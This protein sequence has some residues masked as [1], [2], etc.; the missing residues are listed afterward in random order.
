MATAADIIKKFSKRPYGWNTDEIV[1][2]MAR[3]GLANKIIF[4]AN[5]QNVELRQV[6]EHL[7]KSQKRAN[8]RIRKIKQQSEANLK[9]AA[10]LFKDLGFGTAPNDEKELFNATVDNTDSKLKVWLEKL[11]EFK[12][13]SSTGAYPGTQEIE[14]GIEL[15]SSLTE[16]KSSFQF[17]DQ[18]IASDSKLRN[19]EEEYEELENFYETQF[20]M[21]QGLERAL[22]ISFA[23]NRIFL[24]K[25]TEAKQAIDKLEAIYADPRPYREIRNIKPLI[26]KVT[27]IDKT[28]VEQQREFTISRLE[29]RITE[30]TELV[31]NAAATPEISNRALL[32]F[33]NA[34]KRVRTED[35]VAQIK[36]E[37]I[38]SDDWF[39]AAETLV[40]DY[41]RLRHAQAVKAKEEADKAAEREFKTAPEITATGTKPTDYSAA[42]TAT[43]P[44]AESTPIAIPKAKPTQAIDAVEVYRAVSDAT[45]MESV[46][47][48]DLYITALRK[49]LTELVESNHKVR[50]R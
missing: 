22:K 50:I 16:L 6:Y 37:L 39:T 34:I 41:I 31:K 5:Q 9:K 44:V 49:K 26:E 47:D 32:P 18:F 43:R 1:L 33:Q 24:D 7:S 8:L 30:V 15:I 19:F 20:S 10:K 27:N 36:H 35:T 13:M 38:E 48:V 11:K 25:N 46:E 28:F 4:Q 42:A 12:S 17:V 40:N 3:L 14:D 23:H 2:I 45:Y 29:L 21:W